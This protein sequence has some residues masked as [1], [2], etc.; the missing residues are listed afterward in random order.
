MH[1]LEDDKADA[2]QPQQPLGEEIDAGGLE[3]EQPPKMAK[4][5]AAARENQPRRPPSTA[6]RFS[7]P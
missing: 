7:A 2:R 4:L 3:R 5:V 1:V 6:R